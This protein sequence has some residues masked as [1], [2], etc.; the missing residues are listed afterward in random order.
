[1]QNK[2]RRTTDCVTTLATCV[3]WNLP[4]IPCLGIKTGDF[5]DDITYAIVAKLCAI[6]GGDLD[7]INLQC[8]IDKLDI[9]EPAVKTVST[10]LQL[11]FDNDCA[12]YDLIQE[13]RTLIN[14]EEAPLTLDLKCLTVLDSFN[15]PLPYTLQ[16]VLQSLIT[17]A[18]IVRSQI[19]GLNG[20]IITVNQRID[21]LPTP[22]VEPSL[23]SACLYAGTKPLNQL[24]TI[25][26]TDYCAY[27]VVVGSI[28]EIQDAISR[29]P[30]IANITD[31]LYNHP[32]LQIGVTN[33]GQDQ[34]NQW[35]FIESLLG[36]LVALEGCA[37][38]IKCDDIKIGFEIFDSSV[39]ASSVE[40]NFGLQYGFYLPTGSI[41][42]EVKITFIDKDKKQLIYTILNPS[43]TFIA[44]FAPVYN[45][46]ALNLNDP[47]VIKVCTKIQINGNEVCCN[48]TEKEHMFTGGCGF[49]TITA[50]DDVTIIYKI[51]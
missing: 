24:V 43:T 47:I 46:S 38:K 9:T 1:M 4:D 36:R 16:T 35:V 20:A 21:N 44:G 3:K 11:A 17:E 49:C 25:L 13:V 50:T 42:Q 2:N 7:T 40:L 28:P 27:K 23:I 41:P 39:D 33:M 5:L 30:T 14:N 6:T 31:P 8:L 15:N 12:L 22:Y 10:F 51:C 29:Q 26:A 45:L 34:A 48:C 18:C 37:C 32:D 19:A